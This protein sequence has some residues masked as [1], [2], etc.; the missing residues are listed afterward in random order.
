MNTA[1]KQ[2]LMRASE[3]HLGQFRKDGVTPYIVHP[4]QAA[5]L[6]ARAGAD[7]DTI[8]AGLL[9]DTIEDTGY[10]RNALMREFGD[11]VSEMV[12]ACSEDKSITDWEA[13]KQEL[14]ARLVHASRGAKLVKTADALANMLDLC[15][16]LKT[17][18]G[19]F[20]KKFCA[21]PAQKIQYFREVLAITQDALPEA[22][23]ASYQQA[24]DDLTL[25]VL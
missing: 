14:F 1:V 8:A 17:T 7:D 4:I 5:L 22:L 23:R 21:T 3:L 25:R 9:H 18:N 12:L 19:S 24:L 2:A 20:W 13:R 6:L 16:A 11:V 10:P 15:Q